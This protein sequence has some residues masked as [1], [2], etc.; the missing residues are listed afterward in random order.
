MIQISGRQL[1]CP[2]QYVNDAFRITGR[3]WGESSDSR[4]I[5]VTKGK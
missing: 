4:W 1:Y 5:P 2:M 3:L